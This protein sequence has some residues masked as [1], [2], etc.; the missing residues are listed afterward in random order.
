ML[1]EPLNKA[2]FEGDPC[3]A[4]GRLRAEMTM[5]IILLYDQFLCYILIKLAMY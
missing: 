5:M 3:P 4:V 1:L 2:T